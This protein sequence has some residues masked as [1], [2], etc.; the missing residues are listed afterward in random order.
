MYTVFTDGSSVGNPGSAG[1]GFV[2]YDESKNTLYQFSSNIGKTTNNVAEYKAV[3][4]AMQYCIDMDYLDVEFFSDSMLIVKQINNQWNVNDLTLK[5]LNT[6]VNNLKK[7]FRSFS[8][9][10]ISREKNQVAD[11]L[12]KAGS[13]SK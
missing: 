7:K 3:L 10:Y 8:I 6:Q 5:S 12:A 13:L 4:Y 1:I 2:V 9:S 11:N